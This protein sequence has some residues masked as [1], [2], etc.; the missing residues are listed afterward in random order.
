[1]TVKIALMR[2]GGENKIVAPTE[3]WLDKGSIDLSDL[4]LKVSMGQR[5]LL[6][7]RVRRGERS[8]IHLVTGSRHDCD[9]VRY[10]PSEE[11]RESVG[12]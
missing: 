4:I 10:Q 12:W 5:T 7:P 6:A 3:L 1:M 8:D 11:S 9:M 2:E